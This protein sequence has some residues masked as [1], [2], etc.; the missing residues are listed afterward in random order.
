[1]LTFVL[2]IVCLSLR[3]QEAET[4]IA[5]KPPVPHVRFYD[6]RIW[7]DLDGAKGTREATDVT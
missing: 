7:K 2:G 6:P 3:L 5:R 1:M 4:V